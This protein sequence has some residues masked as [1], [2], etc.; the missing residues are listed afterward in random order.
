MSGVG[1][2]IS[3]SSSINS[4]TKDQRQRA[5]HSLNHDHQQHSSKQSNTASNTAKQ[6][7]TKKQQRMYCTTHKQPGQLLGVVRIERVV[8]VLHE[9]LR[10]LFG[11]H[12]VCEVFAVLIERERE[13][14]GGIN[15]GNN[16]VEAQQSN[17]A[18]G[19]GC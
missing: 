1:A 8:V 6:S 4:N 11:G 18:I 19:S 9:G 10:D 7:Q 13:K 12:D 2:K 15:E 3:S 17:K 16:D 5:L 14:C